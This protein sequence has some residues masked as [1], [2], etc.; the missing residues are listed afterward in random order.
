MVQ[1]SFP[2]PHLAGGRVSKRLLLAYGLPGL[3]IAAAGL[4]LFIFLPT[5]YSSELGIGLTAVGAALLISRLWDVVTDPVVGAL[6]DMTKSRFGRRKPWILAGLPLLMLAIWMLFRPPEGVGVLYLAGWS[7]AVYLA[8]TMISLP[9]GA[10][11]AEIS[12]DYHERSRISAAREVCVVLGTVA[13]AAMPAILGAGKGEAPEGEVL[14]T[15]A[16]VLMVVLPI[17]VIAAL[18]WVPDRGFK[19]T[20]RTDWSQALSLLGGNRPFR[21]LIMA[22]LINGIANGLPATLFLLFVQHVLEAKAQQGLLLLIYFFCGIISVPMW[23]LLSRKLGKHRTWCTAMIANCAFFAVVPFLGAG[24]AV[25]FGFVCVFTGLCLGADLTLPASIQADVVDIDTAKGGERR[26]GIYFAFWGMATKLALALAVGVA[27]PL[28]DVFGFD[29]GGDNQPLAL[30]TL[31]LLYGGL[32][33]VFKIG[34]IGLMWNFP[35]DESMQTDLRAQ[36]ERMQT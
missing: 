4:P 10:W 31:A 1:H 20:K 32:P 7:L 17:S 11:G 23:L 3:P 35:L 15:L 29:T 24:D 30:L 13:A 6:S 33:I 34:A 18:A 8:W 28:L 19:L 14:S 12:D 21:R 16:V 27:F 26:T 22:Y 36:I 2:S 5:F 25:L 9:H